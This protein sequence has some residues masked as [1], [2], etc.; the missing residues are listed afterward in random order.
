[1]REARNLR[2]SERK[3]LRERFPPRTWGWTRTWSTIQAR[4]RTRRG[5]T[6][7]HRM[8]SRRRRGIT[9]SHRMLSST[10]HRP[11]SKPTTRCLR[12]VVRVQPHQTTSP[13][14]PHRST[15]GTFRA[16]W[17]RRRSPLVARRRGDPA[18]PQRRKDA[19]SGRAEG[20]GFQPAFAAPHPGQLDGPDNPAGPFHHARLRSSGSISS[21]EEHGDGL[22]HPRQNRGDAWTVPV[23]RVPSL[24]E[25]LKTQKKPKLFLVT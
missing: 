17:R 19:L 1:M 22:A 21:L 6:V 12:I 16:F 13:N 23:P 11:G 25:Q 2:R 9:V 7:S 10:S 3:W 15:I 14:P 8:P 20:F 18:R 5:I 24:S 4:F